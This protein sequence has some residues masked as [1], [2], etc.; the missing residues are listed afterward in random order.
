[1]LVPSSNQDG[2]AVAPAITTPRAALTP[3]QNGPGNLAL[4]SAAGDH[5]LN[6]TEQH[7]ATGV[8]NSP[9]S[10]RT[11]TEIAD[12]PR[13]II[14]DALRPNV[15]PASIVNRKQPTKRGRPHESY[16]RV[17]FPRSSNLVSKLDE[18]MPNL[19]PNRDYAPADM[20]TAAV[21][22]HV[23]PDGMDDM[24]PMGNGAAA[25]AS[26]AV[27]AHPAH[28]IV[29]GSPTTPP[30]PSTVLVTLSDLRQRLRRQQTEIM[31]SQHPEM[32]LRSQHELIN[33]LKSSF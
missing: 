30:P 2:T 17:T 10:P 18:P 20:V 12:V 19:Q 8:H 28:I 9:P 24:S 1:M 23:M 11:N 22:T 29:V 26:E 3:P 27:V 31:Q 25:S 14:R 33:I 21:D 6:G 4:N 5:A 15:E 32:H 7:T 16:A 13:S